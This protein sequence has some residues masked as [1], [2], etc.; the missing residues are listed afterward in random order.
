VT[1]IVF[2]SEVGDDFARIAAHLHQYAPLDVEARIADIIHGIDVLAH[3]PLIGRPAADG[4]RELVIGRNTYGYLALYVYAA[5][6]DI[7]SIL[8]VRAQREAGYSQP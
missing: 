8:A 2:S 3:N 7:V 6:A 4:T 5:E 1:H